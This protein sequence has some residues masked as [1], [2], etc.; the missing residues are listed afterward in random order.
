MRLLW[1]ILLVA[2]LLLPGNAWGEFSYTGD[3]KS[4]TKDGSGAGLTLSNAKLRIYV[5]KSNII[6]IR[7]T[8]EDKFSEVPSYAVIYD[9]KEPVQFSV[10]RKRGM[11]EVKTD[12]LTL[13]IDENPCRITFLDKGGNILNEDEKSFGMSFDGEEVRC[14]KKLFKDEKF[15]GLGEKTG[16]LSRTGD[17]Y[18]MW[19]SDFPFYT[20][21]TDP[22]YAS[23][24]FFIG[25]RDHKAY[26]IFLDNTYRSQF[27]MGAGSD[28]FYWFGADKGEL[29]YYFIYGPDPKRVIS[30][31]T[32]LTGR[33][34]LPPLWALGF[35]QSRWSYGSEEK[36]REIA[37]QFR[38]REIPCDVIYLDIDY[39]NGYRVFTWNREKFPDP[40]RMMADL[41]RQ[42]FK[43]VPIIDP[44]VKADD[45][46]F[47]AKEGLAGDHFAKYPDGSPY[48]G[49]VWPSWAYFPDFT[50][51]KTR[52]W[53]G[54]NLSIL[55]DAGVAGFWNDMN[56]P[57]VWGKNVPDIIRFSDGGYQADHKKIHNVFALQ[58]AKATFDRLSR[59]PERR[60][61]V[62][63]RAGFSGIQRYAAMWTGDNYANEDHLALACYMPQSMG[64][65]GLPFTGSDV[66]GFGGTPSPALFIR[67]LELGAF[68]PFFRAHSCIDTPDKE[69]W[70]FGAEAEKIARETIR[71]RYRFLPCLYNEFRRSTLTGLPIMRA[72][73]LEYPGD[74]E[75]YAPDAQKEFMLGDSL[76]VAP[77]LSEK[78]ILKKLYLPEGYWLNIWDHKHYKGSQWIAIEAPLGQ[79]PLFL[80]RGA[81]IPQWDAQNYVGEHENGEVEFSIFPGESS[82]Y[83]YYED[84]GISRKYKDGAYA[85]T[86]IQVSE[87]KVGSVRISISKTYDRY[88]SKVKSYRL[89]LFA[90]RL[91]AE[92]SVNGR[93]LE[94]CESE[95]SLM[96]RTEGYA[97]AGE[98]VILI[99]IPAGSPI[100][101]NLN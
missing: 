71:M 17:S 76:L 10:D 94:R 100:E 2:A 45:G 48:K 15:F 47:A 73:F 65:S 77:V 70:T 66:G 93:R 82:S 72:L 33:M 1:K 19:N 21:A 16:N 46:Y 78:D 101:V 60:P 92:I 85:L 53:W 52:A 4:L 88:D 43:I 6:R 8:R 41:A 63:T 23:I 50:S 75:C 59:D 24:P 7:L 28:R 62:L 61:F 34:E 22:I 36:V 95:K 38:T 91:P 51:E 55:L 35:Q 58:M 14:F 96:A 30:S 39:M 32:E 42:G 49:E 79:I 31:Y 20:K 9:K 99:K 64:I 12:E 13:R 81:I 74:D 84:D 90:T 56:E 83:E 5:V 54:N 3:V 69:P 11:T 29:D 40:P 80:R 57:A 86:N 26:G 44:G 27:S 25:I 89:R 98:G 87:D 68:T 67:W 18:I 37:K 97:Q